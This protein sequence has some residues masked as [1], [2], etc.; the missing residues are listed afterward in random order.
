[1]TCDDGKYIQQMIWSE[2]LG[3]NLQLYCCMNLAYIQ[4]ESVKNLEKGFNT[5][6]KCKK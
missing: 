3:L 6:Q 4:T 1:M 2:K 5:M